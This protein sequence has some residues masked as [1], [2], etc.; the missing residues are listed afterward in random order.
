[1][2][3]KWQYYKNSMLIKN[4]RECFFYITFIKLT[5]LIFALQSSRCYNKILAKL[6]FLGNFCSNLILIIKVVFLNLHTYNVWRG[7]NPN[8]LIP[9]QSVPGYISCRW[10]WDSRLVSGASC[11]FSLNC[12]VE[13]TYI[14]T[15]SNIVIF[16]LVIWLGLQWHQDII[17]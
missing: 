4:F 16:Y 9:W 11:C 5:I 10:S 14:S 15:H 2:Y 6:T 17:T 7:H 12:I 3:I 8:C 13:H 1:M